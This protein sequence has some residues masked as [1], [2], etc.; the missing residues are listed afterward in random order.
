[1]TVAG[2][3]LLWVGWFGFNGGSAYAAGSRAAMAI[4]ATHLAASSGALTWGAIEWRV[5][6]KPTVLGVISGALAGLATVTPA[7]GY[8]LPW[9]GQLLGSSRALFASSRQPSSRGC[10][11]MTTPSTHSAYAALAA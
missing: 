4:I 8:I 6:G 11:A 5:R 9:H 10:S 2:A 7:S 1:M 3:G